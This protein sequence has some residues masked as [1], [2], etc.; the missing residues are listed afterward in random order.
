MVLEGYS[1]QRGSSV[2]STAP[3]TLRWGDSSNAMSSS[4]IGNAGNN[5][6]VVVTG[7]NFAVGHYV[8]I[9]AGTTAANGVV[10]ALWGRYR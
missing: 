1:I 5:E 9:A 7:L 2:A 10:G 6:A 4:P 3:D 8:G